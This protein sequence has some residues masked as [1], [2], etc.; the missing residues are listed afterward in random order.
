M[1]LTLGKVMR[2]TA[3]ESRDRE[4]PFRQGTGLYENPELNVVVDAGT[5]EIGAGDERRGAIRNHAFRMQAFS[6]HLELLI[7]T[8]VLEPRQPRRLR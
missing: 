2:A 7:E 8:E 1:P 5:C 4:W 3:T 6:R